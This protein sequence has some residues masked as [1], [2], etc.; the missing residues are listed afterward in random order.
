MNDKFTRRKFIKS[1]TI[2]GGALLVSGV[3]FGAEGQLA[4]SE[5]AAVPGTFL[6]G[7]SDL[8]IHAMPDTGQRSVNELEL[9]RA[10]QQAG[11]IFPRPYGRCTRI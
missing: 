10:A 11:S 4:S 5:P 7:V 9:S 2:A 6:K 1:S 8:H 3:P